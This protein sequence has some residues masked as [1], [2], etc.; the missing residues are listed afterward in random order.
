[1]NTAFENGVITEERLA[2]SVK[3]ILLYKYKAALNNYQPINTQNLYQDLNK[4]EYTD[5]SY[6]LYEQVVT[7]LKNDKNLL[8]LNSDKANSNAYARVGVDVN[9]SFI[10][11]LLAYLSI[12]LINHYDIGDHLSDV[13]ACDLVNVG[14]HKS[15]GGCKK[16]VI[17]TTRI[18]KLDNIVKDPKSIF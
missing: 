7:V 18:N 9:D 1:F 16:H 14:Y 17:L 3:K 13:K 5:L 12:T 15:D 8:P 11:D 6:K 4:Q 2:H 10:D